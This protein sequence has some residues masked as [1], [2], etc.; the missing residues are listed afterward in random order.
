MNECKSEKKPE[1]ELKPDGETRETDSVEFGANNNSWLSLGAMLRE[2]IDR[3][4]GM[5]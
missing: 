5:D 2:I 3:D 4:E 1:V